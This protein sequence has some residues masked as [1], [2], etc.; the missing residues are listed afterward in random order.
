MFM[1]I[2]LRIADMST[3][4]GGTMKKV[5]LLLVMGLALTTGSIA[6]AGNQA[7]AM[8]ACETR[9]YEKGVVG[10]IPY[11]AGGVG[12]DERV[13]I[14]PLEKDYNLKLVFALRSGQYLASPMIAVQDS[15]GKD[16]LRMTSDGPWFLAKLPAGEYKVIVSRDGHRTEIEHVKVG[17]KLD[18]AEFLWKS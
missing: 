4:G 1:A 12:Q 3:N 16:V 9:L 8:S 18:T 5:M 15:N 7:A 17:Q 14:G 11:L 2:K 6:Y 13:C 10:S